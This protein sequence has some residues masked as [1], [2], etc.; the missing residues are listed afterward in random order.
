MSKS[1]IAPAYLKLRAGL[2]EQI[3]LGESR[4]ESA[5]HLNSEF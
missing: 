2:A 4:P 5:C 1:D 3:I